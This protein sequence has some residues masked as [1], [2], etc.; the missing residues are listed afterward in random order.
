AIAAGFFILPLTA[1]LIVRTRQFFRKK[2]PVNL[3]AGAYFASAVFMFA[4]IVYIMAKGPMPHLENTLNAHGLGTITVASAGWKAAGIFAKSWF[5]NLAT[6]L[7]IISMTA[8]LALSVSIGG[9]KG[10]APR[11]KSMALVIY[12]CCFQFAFSMLGLKF[13][14]RYIL[15]LLPCA[16]LVPA[17]A[18]NTLKFSRSLSLAVMVLIAALS[19]AGT[20]D[21]LAWNGAKWKAGHLAGAAGIPLKEVANGFDW[22]GH[23]NYEHNMA[24][25][26]S[27]QALRAIGEWDWQSMI[28]FKAITSFKR[29]TPHPVRPDRTIGSIEYSTPLSSSDAYIYLLRLR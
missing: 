6:A 16:V 17:F 14:D 28:R 24:R 1:G 8:F 23:W 3:T 21:Y 22:D 27:A 25:L 10:S 4:C 9:T 7:G 11:N 12:V 19:W 15:T 18:A 29:D 5:W 13:F 2:S 26:K 20:K